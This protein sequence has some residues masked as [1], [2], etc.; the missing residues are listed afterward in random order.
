[1]SIEYTKFE[2]LEFFDN[3][4]IIDTETQDVEYSLYVE[5]VFIFKLHIMPYDQYASITLNYNKW[6]MFVCNIGMDN[7]TKISL[8]RSKQG[9]AF[10]NFY[11]EGSEEP[12]L[13]VTLKPTIS[14]KYAL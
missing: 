4:R 8:D 1:M 13:T 5:D 10:L 14:F 6:E 3:E 2:M 12:L 9:C 11:R 7:I